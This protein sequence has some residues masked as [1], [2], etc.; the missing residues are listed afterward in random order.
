MSGPSAAAEALNYA[1]P[2]V[3][4]ALQQALDSLPHYRCG[5]EQSFCA[6]ASASERKN[7][8]LPSA[9]AA[10]ILQDGIAS[11]MSMHCQMDW[12]RRQR[13]V[14]IEKWRKQIANP[15]RHPRALALAES[16]H[17]VIRDD[18]FGHLSRKGPCTP[19]IHALTTLHLDAL[20]R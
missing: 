13:A 15:N 7:P 12:H 20:A 4:V 8:P 3:R 14:M 6:S 19:E 1:T 10:L 2:P 16:L 5:P 18:A 17:D 11:G 9:L